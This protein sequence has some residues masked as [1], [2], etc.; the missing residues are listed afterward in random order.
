MASVETDFDY[1][2]RREA[3]AKALAERSE[4]PGIRRI[5]E[6]FA[7][8]YAERARRRDQEPAG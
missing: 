2:A 1:Y 6:D 4:D 8:R 7:R 3:Q 5:H